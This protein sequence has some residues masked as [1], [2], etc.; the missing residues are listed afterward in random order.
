MHVLSI[1]WCLSSA[2]GFTVAPPPTVERLTINIIFAKSAVIC[3]LAECAGT[4]KEA[5][6]HILYTVYSCH[7][8]F[9]WRRTSRVLLV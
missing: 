2:P 6:I 8:N 3:V 4:H 1:L 7:Y 9:A 5:H